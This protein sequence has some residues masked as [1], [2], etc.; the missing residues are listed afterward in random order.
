MHNQPYL[1]G[2]IL[3]AD[4]VRAQLQVALA[5]LDV[6]V[7]GIVQV[8]IDDLLGERQGA[9]EPEEEVNTVITLHS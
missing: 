6:L 2:R 9:V 3:H 8:S 7:L 4:A 1:G 5:T